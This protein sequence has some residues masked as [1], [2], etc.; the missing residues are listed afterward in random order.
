MQHFGFVAI[1]GRPNVGKS[2]LM[3]HL[4]GEKVSITTRKPQTTRNLIQGILTEGDYQCVFV[5]TPGLQQNDKSEIKR[6][7]NRSAQGAAEGVQLILLVVDA[8]KQN[9][10][11][12]LVFQKLQG[13][14][15]PVIL[16]INKV[17]KVKDKSRL[18]PIIDRL[19]EKVDFS[20][21]VPVSALREQNIAELKETIKKYMPEE[22]HGYN[23][24]IVTNIEERFRA[25][26][27][28]REKIMRQMG[29]ELPYRCTV[30][31]D[32]FSRI[33]SSDIIIDIPGDKPKRR[34]R[35]RQH[36][37]TLISASILVDR[38]SQKKM[39]IGKGG[40]RIKKI[41]IEARKDL[42][43]WLGMKVD[44]HLYVK[45]KKKWKQEREPENENIKFLRELEEENEREF[46][47]SPKFTNK[48]T[49]KK[50]KDKDY[51]F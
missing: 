39:V 36:E 27:I 48:K 34:P 18:L 41:G 31:V 29:D 9:E 23:S 22:E 26:E 8:L 37:F 40:A 16:V 12:E 49:G 17:D 46:P 28:I 3:N 32:E 6:M 4:I 11:D 45:T 19:K 25:A 33:T 30:N 51:H 1:M 42:E 5:D 43:S 24:N 38:D 13:Q 50:D 10:D 2:T 7:L 20:E 35:A 47:S 14:K 44:L 15:A 21:I